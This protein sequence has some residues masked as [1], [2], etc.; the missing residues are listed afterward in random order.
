MANWLSA[1]ESVRNSGN[2]IQSNPQVREQTIR[3]DSTYIIYFLFEMMS[4]HMMIKERIFTHRHRVSFGLFTF[5][6]WRHDCAML[7]MTSDLMVQHMKCLVDC[8][9]STW[10]MI[11]KLDIGFSYGNIRGRLCKK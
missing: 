7:V 5:W 4:S 2:E 3:Y 9:E 6:W 11:S 8:D 1:D 10:R